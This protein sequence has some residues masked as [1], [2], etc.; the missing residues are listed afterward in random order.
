MENHK[1]MKVI[2]SFLK[3]KRVPGLRLQMVSKGETIF[4]FNY[5]Y[6]N[7]DLK[8][9]MKEDTL[10]SIISISKSFTEV[11]KLHLEENM[12]FNID[13][14]IIE[15]LPY[16]CTKSDRFNTITSNHILSH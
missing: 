4:T 7:I 6:S 3:E 8:K 16:F 10:N 5:G 12:D 9:P 13:T 15:Y 1:V 14:P 2:E 11:E